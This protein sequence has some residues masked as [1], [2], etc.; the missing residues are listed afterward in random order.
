MSE[1]DLEPFLASNRRNKLKQG[2]SGGRIVD[3]MGLF[4]KG[5]FLLVITIFLPEDS[6]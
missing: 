4:S 1:G 6:Q 3:K 5:D 2:V